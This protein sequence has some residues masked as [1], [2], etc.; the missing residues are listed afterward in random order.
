MRIKN[1]TTLMDPEKFLIIAHR[2]ASVQ[3]PEHTMA[4]YRLAKELEA[5]YLEVD[6]QMSK[7]EVLVSIHD[8]TVDR[9][10]DGSGVVADMMLSELKQ[11][12]AGSWFNRKYPDMAKEEYVG[13]KIPTLQEIIEEFG[14]SVN[15]Y[16]ETKKPEENEGVEDELFELLGQYNLLDE[17]LPEGKVVI[18]SFSEESLK[19]MR[20]FSQTIPLIKL[21]KDPVVGPDARRRLEEIREYAIGIGTYFERIDDDYVKTAKE[22]GLL[23][24]LYTVNSAEI[25]EKW[26]AVGA[27]GIFTDN[28]P[29]TRI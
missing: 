20:T 8:L 7:D 3:A 12:D 26:K 27:H 24:H 23:V 1:K 25:A 15:Y 18:Q 6:V 22:V 29:G 2:G 5:D 19:R 9:T 4:A 14:E 10:T 17:S 11:L 16:I 28:I 13:Q 21:E